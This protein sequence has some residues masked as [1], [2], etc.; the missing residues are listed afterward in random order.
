MR[1]VLAVCW[2]AELV[3]ALGCHAAWACADQEAPL[4][5]ADAC[6][7]QRQDFTQA[8]RAADLFRQALSRDRHCERAALGLARV[9]VFT[10]VL[11]SGEEEQRAYRE[12]EEAARRLIEDW[13]LH[14]EGHYWLGVAQALQANASGFFHAIQ[15][16]RTAKANLV[17]ALEL[18]PAYDQ[19][20]PHRVLGRL[21]FKLPAILGGDNHLAE[22]YLR[23]ALQLGPRYWLTHIY[24]AVLL[25]D[26]G[27]AAEA[28]NLLR[29]V[30]A[31]PAQAGQEAEYHIW[32]E[33]ARKLLQ[34]PQAP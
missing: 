22:R 17:R 15:K 25:L 26:Q 20:G 13:P 4:A 7:A 18:D 16:V 34:E 8:E 10:G 27:R 14:V 12:A 31:G 33:Q 3:L 11:S 21:Y 19:G 28:R 23:Q 1:F 2:L 9:S 24:L 32:R 5:Q 30:V 6:F 29:Q